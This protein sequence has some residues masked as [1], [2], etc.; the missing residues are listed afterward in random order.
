MNE[1][2][3][4]KRRL[5]EKRKLN[6]NQV[7]TKTKM[8][9]KYVSNLITRLLIS[10]IIFFASIIFINSN[11]NN[12]KIFSEKILTSNIPFSKISNIYNKYFGEVLP[13]KDVKDE[14]LTVYNE[15]LNYKSLENY[16][17]GYELMV[18]E[19]YLTSAIN[20]GIVVFIGDKENY[21]NTVIIQGIDEID[22]WYGNINNLSVS[23][24]DY[25]SK[26]DLIGTAKGE[27]LYLVFQKNSK[28]LDYDEVVKES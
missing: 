27:K 4:Q 3:I 14:T 15:T 23:L 22:Y 10:L 26:G 18:D 7:Q 13:L 2:E 16:K 19:N 8:N 21:G 12:K 1:V 20:S 17:D 24:Y 25:I 28:F 6:L 9:N 5:K 11:E